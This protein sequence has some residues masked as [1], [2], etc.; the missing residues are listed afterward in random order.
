MKAYPLRSLAV[1]FLVVLS[2]AAVYSILVK[3]AQD[4]AN[5]CAGDSCTPI[6]TDRRIAASYIISSLQYREFGGTGLEELYFAEMPGGYI[7]VYHFNSSSANIAGFDVN[8]TTE[9][10]KVASSVF[11]QIPREEFCGRSTM[12]YCTSDLDCVR[13]GCSASI[14]QAK[15]DEQMLTT[16]EYRDCYDASRYG[17][18]CGCFSGK[19]Q[20]D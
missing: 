11:T 2:A 16:C 6:N 10:G 9:G 14:C 12:S 3:P 18:T 17:L 7:F 1:I 5:G 20:W 4:Y 8:I 19:C 13:G 15:A